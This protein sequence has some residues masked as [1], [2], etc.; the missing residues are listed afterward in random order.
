[1]YGLGFRLLESGDAE[2]AIKILELD[3]EAYPDSA[4]VYDS[5]GEAYAKSGDKT[6]AIENYKKALAIDPT[7]ETSIKA[8]EE[9]RKL[10]P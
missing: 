6:R 8:L 3:V 9:L 4:K 1:M 10:K 5:L 2:G 7:L